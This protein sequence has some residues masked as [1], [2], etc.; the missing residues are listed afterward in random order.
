MVDIDTIVPL[1]L[2]LN[3]LVTNS[4]KYAFPDGA[5]GEI[6][7]EFHK[8]NNEFMLIVSDTGIGFPMDMDFR[9]TDSLGL[10]LVNNLIHQINGTIELERGKGTKFEIKFKELYK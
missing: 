9:S 7:I 1:G 2:V 8:Y 6:N 5:E 4:M 10:K 3:E